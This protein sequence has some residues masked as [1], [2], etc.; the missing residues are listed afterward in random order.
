MR[1]PSLADGLG[2][3]LWSRARQPG[4]GQPQEDLAEA[5]RLLEQAIGHLQT[6]REWI[7]LHPGYR[8]WLGE[9]YHH[10]ANTLTCLGLYRE[11]MAAYEADIAVRATDGDSCSDLAALLLFCPDQQLRDTQRAIELASKAIEREPRIDNSGQGADGSHWG[12]LSWAQYRAGDLAA[13]ATAAEKAL[14]LRPRHEVWWP[15]DGL[16]WGALV[17][18]MVHEKRGKHTQAVA[19]F[20]EAERWLEQRKPQDRQGALWVLRVEAAHVLGIPD[21]GMKP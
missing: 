15:L 7:P 12:V 2:I 8:Q 21:D 20:H 1:R 10:L 9:C 3:L 4:T 5:R 18:A 6:A 14:Q 13:A 19:R 17:L 11:A 16:P